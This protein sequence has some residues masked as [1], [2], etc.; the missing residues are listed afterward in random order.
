MK[1]EANMAYLIPTEKLIIEGRGTT[2][3]GI[4][5]SLLWKVDLSS[6]RG[7]NASRHAMISQPS[8]KCIP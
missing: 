8:K 6:L 7:S 2:G 3:F 1:L 5:V 4:G